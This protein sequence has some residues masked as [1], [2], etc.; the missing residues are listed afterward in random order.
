M[1]VLPPKILFGDLMEGIRRY[2]DRSRFE[3]HF[4]T[5]E[6][7]EHIPARGELPS[8]RSFGLGFRNQA[9][10]P[11]SVARLATLLRTRRIDIVHTHLFWPSVVGLL[12]GRIAAVRAVVQTRHYGDLLQRMGM[13]RKARLYGRI[14][15]HLD[16]TIANSASTK[17]V[18]IEREGVA[19][20]AVEVIPV[21]VQF[22]S[23]TAP[24]AELRAE[25]RL[26]WGGDA[27]F[28]VG[29]VG[30]FV[31]LKGFHLAI[32]AL[33]RVLET[34]P[35]ATLVIAGSGPRKAHLQKV[36][37]DLGI[38][39]AVRLVPPVYWE[40][41]NAFYDSLDAFVQPSLSEGFGLTVVEAMG[42]GKPVVAFDIGP[43]R[44]IVAPGKTGF[45][46]PEGD[47]RAMADALVVLARDSGLRGRIGESAR[48][49]V[50][51]R[52]DMSDMGQR[53]ESVYARLSHRDRGPTVPRVP[54]G[55]SG[56]P[57]GNS[58]M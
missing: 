57:T 50:R 12:A 18:M 39:H 6:A 8:L 53:Y 31:D 49:S 1:H 41:L 36:A 22:D 14:A 13:A 28:L 56:K 11:W 5:L 42:M 21:A 23:F 27:D 20:E 17:R 46:V 2:S 48:E 51:S 38:G 43:M 33:K 34:R 54:T 3:L 55:P 44:E 35:R 9:F 19:P 26:R 16:L 45:L 29:A 24:P 10:L 30:R 32:E 58:P 52:F 7:A 25:N 37:L 40:E 4:S 15:H 47:T